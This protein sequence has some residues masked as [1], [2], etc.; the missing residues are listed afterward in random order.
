MSEPCYLT[1]KQAR[2]FLGVDPYLLAQPVSFEATPQV[3]PPARPMW[4][5][6][7][8]EEARD[9]KAGRYRAPANDAEDDGLESARRKLGVA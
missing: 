6:L 7:T 3:V 4:D 9:R 8:L 2:A 5:R 1:R